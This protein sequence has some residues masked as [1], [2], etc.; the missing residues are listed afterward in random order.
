MWYFTWILGLGAAWFEAE[1]TAYGIPFYTPGE[2][3]KRLGEAVEVIKA[4]DPRPGRCCVPQG[5]SCRR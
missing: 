4:L 1:H 2:R 5:A 3:A